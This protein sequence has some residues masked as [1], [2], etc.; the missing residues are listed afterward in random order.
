MAREKARLAVRV[1]NGLA[2]KGFDSAAMFMRDIVK[3]SGY[4]YK[5]IEGELCEGTGSLFGVIPPT[6]LPPNLEG[7]SGEEDPTSSPRSPWQM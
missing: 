6:S 5:A 4:R 3:S 7:S 2:E 1:F